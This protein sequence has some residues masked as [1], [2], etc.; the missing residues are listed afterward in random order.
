[1][2]E[3]PNVPAQEPRSGSRHESYLEFSLGKKRSL[4]SQSERNIKIT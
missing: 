4:Q 1:M 3:A 2:N